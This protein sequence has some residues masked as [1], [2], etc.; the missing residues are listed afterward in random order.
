MKDLI[1]GLLIGILLAQILTSSSANLKS[2]GG[3][4]CKGLAQTK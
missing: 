2:T 4:P 1:I 3:C